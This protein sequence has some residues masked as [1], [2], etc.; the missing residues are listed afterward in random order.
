MKLAISVLEPHLDSKVDD[1]F[2]RANSLLV[3]DTETLDFV[4]VDN[5][6]NQHALEGAGIGAAELVCSHGIGAVLTGHLGP[7]AY[8]ALQMVGIKGYDATGLI[9]RDAIELFNDDKLDPLS[10]GDSHAGLN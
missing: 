9:A 10:E 7:K 3:V 4:V 1:R 8:G 2:G 6:K 5:S